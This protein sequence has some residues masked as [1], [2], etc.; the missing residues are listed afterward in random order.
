MHFV[1]IGLVLFGIEALVGS[2]RAARR[3][4][5]G[6][7]VAA[8]V[9]EQFTKEQGRA[10]S[11]AELDA[12]LER[13]ADEEIL[14]RAGLERGLEKDDPRI[15]ERVAMKMARVLSEGVIVKDPTEEDLLAW[16][17]AHRE[18]FSTPPLID[19]TQVFVAGSGDDARARAQELR[20]MLEAGSDPAG[21][22][23]TFS[24]GRRY[25]HR[26]IADL[27]ESF[28][29]PFVEGLADQGEGTWVIRVSPHGQHVV[30]VD[31][32]V[33]GASA[34][35]DSARADVLKDWKDEQRKRGLSEATA[36]LRKKWT[37]VRE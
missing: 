24:G 22:G 13:W 16:F 31:K 10:P 5:V 18:R 28:G 11:A 7:D 15:R 6:Q 30:R 17:D 4:V 14:Y 3:V 36:A 29:A 27:A 8:S 19:F 23:D 33:P 35:F 2:D 1:A 12:L 9:A 20:V 37:V 26:K 32:R 25:R 21:L 34:S